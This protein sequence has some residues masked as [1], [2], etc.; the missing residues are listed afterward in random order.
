MEET[1][2]DKSIVITVPKGIGYLSEWKE[3]KIP[4]FPCIVDKQITGCGFTELCLTNE[5]NV[6]LCS[7]RKILLK[8]KEVQHNYIKDKDGNLILNPNPEFPV[9]YAENK[10]EKDQRVDKNTNTKSKKPEAEEVVEIGPND[11]YDFKS[12]IE[13]T[14]T[15]V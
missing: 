1:I 9:Y 12:G 7:P 6:V 2:N 11:I 8:N 10:F 5:D 15:N 13:T 3:F 14:F 4:D